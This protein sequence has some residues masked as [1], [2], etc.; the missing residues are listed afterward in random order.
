[1]VITARSAE[2]ARYALKKIG[3]GLVD[4]ILLDL[5]DLDIKYLIAMDAG[6]YASNP[7]HESAL[8][9]KIIEIFI[10]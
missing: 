9:N 10:K 2:K 6:D 1:M 5:T 8:N 4:Y 7:F 3:P